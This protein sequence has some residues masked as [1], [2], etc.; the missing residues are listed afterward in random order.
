MDFD[1]TQVN[2]TVAVEF[3]RRLCASYGALR[4]S[5][6]PGGRHGAGDFRWQHLFDQAGSAA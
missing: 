6:A 2:A 1:I 5:G 3:Y 4:A